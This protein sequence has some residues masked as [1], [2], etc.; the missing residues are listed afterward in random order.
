MREKQGARTSYQGA[1]EAVAREV[2]L[3][4][5]A[6]ELKVGDGTREAVPADVEE[7]DVVVAEALGEPPCET[8][9]LKVQGRQQGRPRHGLGGRIPSHP[10]IGDGP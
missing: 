5:V 4:Q 10:L 8:L 1:G 3:A 7:L 9:A 6:H 2:Q